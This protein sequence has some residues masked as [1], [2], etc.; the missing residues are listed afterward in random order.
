MR[1][2]SV[3]PL[4]EKRALRG[5]LIQF[6]TSHPHLV[7]YVCSQIL[8]T[9]AVMV[10]RATLEE[11]NKKLFDSI[12]STVSQ[13]LAADDHKMVWQACVCGNTANLI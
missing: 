10:K 7:N 13:L 4:D 3:L 2:W 1:E 6:L 12:L 8:H 11:D 9:V 5:Y